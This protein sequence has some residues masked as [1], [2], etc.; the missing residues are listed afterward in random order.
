MSRADKN[1]S[2]FWYERFIPR[3]CPSRRVAICKSCSKKRIELKHYWVL[4]ESPKL[5]FSD[6]WLLSSCSALFVPAFAWRIDTQGLIGSHVTFASGI[7]A[8]RKRLC[9]W[10]ILALIYMLTCLTASLKVKSEIPL[11]W[12][13]HL[14]VI[15]YLCAEFLVLILN[16]IPN[17]FYV[18]FV[19]GICGKE[20]SRKIKS[21]WIV[22]R[23][24]VFM[25]LYF[26]FCTL[27]DR[28]GIW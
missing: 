10:W 22:P 12:K 23:V 1:A 14:V 9:A 11:V 21:Y 8:G 26:M 19:E 6:R 20:A 16:W 13:S 24:L 25:C 27:W 17:W 3:Q 18:V 2:G 28:F 15:C 7:S 4:I 5:D